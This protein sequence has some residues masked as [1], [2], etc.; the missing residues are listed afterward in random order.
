[1][2]S[3]SSSRNSRTS[4]G[5]SSSLTAAVP[6][7]TAAS[8]TS[9]WTPW[10]WRT[11]DTRHSACGKA[12]AVAAAG[13]AP[14]LPVPALPCRIGVPAV[15]SRPPHRHQF[16]LRAVRTLSVKP[17]PPEA[18][19]KDQVRGTVLPD[20]DGDVLVAAAYLHG[21]GS[22]PSLNRLR[23]G[24]R[25]PTPL[26]ARHGPT[27]RRRRSRYAKRQ[28]KD[29]PLVV[30][31]GRL[32]LPSRGV[33]PGLLRAQPPVELRTRAVRWRRSRVLAS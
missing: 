28:V 32:E 33:V 17:H 29:L 4:W 21:I 1:M 2:W 3:C 12:T 16:D 6:G 11:R 10:G 30:E 22:A 24:S 9:V 20:E 8:S 13:E 18:R 14:R 26:P 15:G 31:V 27:P 7:S 5:T 25:R 23:N 19:F